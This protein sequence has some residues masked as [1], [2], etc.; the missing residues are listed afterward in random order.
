MSKR[1][2]TLNP[3]ADPEVARRYEAWYAGEGQRADMLEKA[4]LGKLLDAFGALDSV[5]EVGCGTGHFTRWMAQR[6]LHAVGIDASEPMLS[7]ALRRGGAHYVAGDAHALPFPDRSHDLTAM[8]TTLEF[9]A[10]PARALGE[11]VRVARQGLLL[12]AL[13]RWS[14]VALR[15]RLSSKALW[16]CARFFGPWE[17][18]NLV[19]TAAGGRARRVLWRTT[20]WPLPFV[21]DLG[22]PWGGFIGMAVQLRDGPST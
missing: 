21:H 7:E 19:R 18:A 10:D 17:L 1:C 5:L 9:L 6:N 11:A 15:H 16:R 4:L 14:W 22:L 2:G 20:L 12:G 3:F 13:N 8:I